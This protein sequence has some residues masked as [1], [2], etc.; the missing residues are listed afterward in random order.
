MRNLYKLKTRRVISLCAF[1]WML[2]GLMHAEDLDQYQAFPAVFNLSSLNGNNGFIINGINTYTGSG[3]FV[4]GAGDINGDGIADILIG[5][6]ALSFDSNEARLFDSNYSIPQSYLVFGSKNS[7]PEAINLADLN[8]INGFGINGINPNDLA[9]SVRRAGDVNGDG[10]ADILIGDFH[11]NGDIGQS[12]VV[13]GS[14]ASWPAV[15]DLSSLN[16]S[17][18]FAIKGISRF[19]WSGFSTSGIGDVNGDGIADILIGASTKS[20]V[21]FGSKASWPASIDLDRLNGNNGFAISGPF[22]QPTGATGSV[23]GPGDVNGDGIADILIGSPSALYVKSQCYVVF[24]SKKS[25]LP[26]VDLSS[27]NGSNG[28]VLNSTNDRND[29]GSSVSGAGDVNG[30]GI[31]DMLI[32]GYIWNNNNAGQ[33]YVVFGSKEPWP[34]AIDLDKLNGSNGFVIDGINSDDYSGWSVSGIG[35]VN[36]DGIADIL[37]GAPNANNGRGQSY[38]IFGSK[39]LWPATIEL[40]D[41]NGTNG[42]AVNGIVGGDPYSESGYSVSGAG[43]V[44]G[45]GIPDILIGAPGVIFST[46]QSY[47]IFG[48]SGKNPGQIDLILELTLGIGGGVVALTGL[49]IGGYYG[50]HHYYRSDYEKI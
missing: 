36:G 20:Y 38:V 7:W 23:A 45:D 40:S 33:I 32:G 46:G 12:Y 21:I 19:S 26:Q 30:D 31:A 28:F 44:N 39:K 49:G 2:W 10:V 16:G 8:G 4:S 18:G 48:D 29:W 6:K 15:I 43:D 17:N 24:G 9:A 22:Y 42:F 14:K 50:Y 41:L 5:I 47:I 34:P 25:W 1:A 3:A 27:L 11:A 35:D 13:F 37:I